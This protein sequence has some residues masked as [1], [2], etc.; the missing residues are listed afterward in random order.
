MKKYLLAAACGIFLTAG[1]ASAQ[2]VVH[3]G[4]PPPRHEVIPPPRHGYVWHPGYQR[5]D[6]HAYVWTPGEYVVAPR[7]GAHWVPGHW[8]H[9]RGGW[10]WIEGHWR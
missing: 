4:P 7:P 6:G 5:W 1:I 10:V 3:I 2:V 8:S 9:R